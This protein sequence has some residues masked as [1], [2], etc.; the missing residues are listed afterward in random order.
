MSYGPVKVF[1]TTIASGATL[2]SEVN[3]GQA[4]NVAYLEIAS[5]T[6]NAQHHIQAAATSGGTYRR[7]TVN[8]V[9]MTTQAAALVVWQV[10][11]SVTSHMV[12]IPPGLQY[13]KVETDVSMAGGQAYRI[14]CAF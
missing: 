9:T 2:S 1:S 6:S 7:V 14:L 10:H 12:P 4:W 5:M 11:S 8:P 3:L 13:V